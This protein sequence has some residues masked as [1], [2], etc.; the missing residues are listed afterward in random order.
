MISTARPQSQSRFS[1]ENG[2]VATRTREVYIQTSTIC[3]VVVDWSN[4]QL[5]LERNDRNVTATNVNM[6]EWNPLN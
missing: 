5:V 3:T 2:T 6:S 1:V 4:C